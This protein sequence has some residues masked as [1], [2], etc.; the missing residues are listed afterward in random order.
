MDPFR[1]HVEK[2]NQ[3]PSSPIL[4]VVERLVEHFNQA[5]HAVTWETNS[6]S[7]CKPTPT[8]NG[9]LKIIEILDSKDATTEATNDDPPVLRYLLTCL[10][11]LP[12]T[13]EPLRV[14]ME[15]MN[16]YPSH[17]RPTLLEGNSTNLS[18]RAPIRTEGIAVLQNYVRIL[19]RY[20]LMKHPTPLP[21]ERVNRQNPIIMNSPQYDHWDYVIK[22]ILSDITTL[23]ASQRPMKREDRN[24]KDEGDSSS[25]K[26]P[27]T[28]HSL[29]SLWELVFIGLKYIL[30]SVDN[31]ALSTI[32]RAICS[33]L[34]F[35]IDS[36]ILDIRM[37]E[38]NLAEHLFD[39]SLYWAYRPVSTDQGRRIHSWMN[40]NAQGPMAWTEHF[41]LDGSSWIAESMRQSVR[42]LWEILIQI[43]T[44]ATLMQEEMTLRAMQRR[45]VEQ[46][47]WISMATAVRAHFFGRDME[48]YRDEHIVPNPKFR[49]HLGHLVEISPQAEE[50]EREK[51]FMDCK[52]HALIP[53]RLHAVLVFISLLESSDVSGYDQ[54]AFLE[55]MLPICYELL[56]SHSDCVVGIGG[57]ILYRLLHGLSKAELG[58]L[59]CRGESCLA[60]IGDCPW[61]VHAD[62]VL[63]A[64]DEVTRT[65]RVGR[66][67]VTIGQVQRDLLLRLVQLCQNKHKYKMKRR[68]VTQYWLLVLEQNQQ[69]SLHAHL[70]WGILIVVTKLLN[71][72]TK[73]ENAD[74]FELGRPGLRALLPFIRLHY[75]SDLSSHGPEVPTLTLLALMNL[76]IA[77]HP[78]IHHHAGKIL[79]E[80]L[81]CIAHFSKMMDEQYMPR[82]DDELMSVLNHVTAVAFVICGEAAQTVCRRLEAGDYDGR[83]KNAVGKIIGIASSY[84]AREIEVLIADS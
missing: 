19:Q 27:S 11:E 45:C 6:I 21:R 8:Q 1:D 41:L 76:L 52:P 74:G 65:C 12:I 57:V 50:E 26:P 37:V 68:S 56:N 39:M 62:N 35:H 47:G 79:C 48:R 23:T 75:E 9:S 66:T 34:P 18:G 43:T 24:N 32:R 31:N 84:C 69:S 49:L 29:D 36:T 4:T 28:L 16:L 20:I 25:I 73:Q 33:L 83:V 7:V 13:F 10:L 15:W 40:Q 60:R 77:A 3:G 51:N 58:N 59:T 46:I 67:L 54:A 17:I 78:M 22:L 2:G 61:E 42:Q 44:P 81:A 55:Q 64:L 38:P 80:L 70:A 5:V 63:T 82:V 71:D 72:H 30:I 14:A 53:S